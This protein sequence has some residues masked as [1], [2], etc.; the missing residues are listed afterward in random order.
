MNKCFKIFFL[1]FALIFLL[2]STESIS[3]VTSS[4]VQDFE[5]KVRLSWEQVEGAV[6]YRVVIQDFNYK[7]V[8]DKSINSNSVIIEIPAGKYKIRIGS[9]NKFGKMATWSDWADISIEEPK[10]PVKEVIA[11]KPPPKSDVFNLGLKIGAGGS[12][13]YIL[14]VWDDYYK[15]SY[16]SAFINV[17]YSFRFLDSAKAFSVLKYTGI[18]L[19]SSFIS[20]KGIKAFN[21]IESDIDDIFAGSSLLLSSKFS[22]P[23]NF[24]LRGGGGVVFTI[25]HYQKYDIY[26]DPVEKNTA[27]SVDYFIK[28]GISMEYRFYSFYFLEAFADFYNIQ[29]KTRQFNTIRFSCLAG[30]RF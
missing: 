8:F 26:N 10:P 14:P 28:A 18:D 4:G 23:L 16:K 24:T 13:F 22:F 29:Y 3:Q 9:L 17:A 20:F 30:I 2:I 25:M 11:V 27:I 12:Y 6:S 21:R 7:T 19:D 15:N 1:F 5:R